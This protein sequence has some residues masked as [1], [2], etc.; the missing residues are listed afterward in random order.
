MK[1][2]WT[3]ALAGYASLTIGLL[4]IVK[5]IVPGFEYTRMG[6]WTGLLPGTEATVARTTSLVIGVLLMMIAHGL[7]RGKVRAWRAVVVLLPVN[8]AVAFIHLRP[9]TA[10][11]SLSILAVLVGERGQFAALSDPRSRWR[12]LGNLLGLGALDLALGYLIV[13]AR[14]R[15][16]IGHPDLLDRLEHVALGL[17][18]VEGPVVFTTDRVGDL[19]YFSLAALGTLTAI[20]TLY[21]VLR[22]ERPVAVLS[23]EDERRL[24]VLLERHGERDSLGYF[25][26]RRDKSALF[27]PSGKAAIAYRVVSGVML[28]SGDPIGDPE[29]WP[30][31]IKVFMAEA[32]RRA[33]VPAVIGCGEVGGEVWTRVAGMSALEIGDEA[34][35]E[36]ADFTLEGRAMRNV[37]HMV[38][39]IERAGFHCDVRRVADLPEAETERV[40]Q[41]AEV[42]RGT[43]TERGYSMALGRCGDPACLVTTA[44]KDGELRA[45]LHFVPW[46]R[47]AS[48]ST[49][50]A[51]TATRGRA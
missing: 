27:S 14:P 6:E 50:C 11:I 47:T 44:Y 39:R 13:S 5:A 19:V 35:V 36:V 3:P 12:A 38:N 23:E 16:I 43:Q 9:V 22:P 46:A 51:A 29:A 2:S 28:A 30:A 15:A 41:A 25:A 34:V 31:A 8:A 4:G 49:S 18:G 20:T 7:R 10:V 21:L 32:R 17:M 40:R 33:W 37:R 45:M 48:R 1:H 26:L 24:R 42:W